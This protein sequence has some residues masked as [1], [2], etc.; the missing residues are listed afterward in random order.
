MAHIARYIVESSASAARPASVQTTASREQSCQHCNY[1]NNYYGDQ[2]C[3]PRT[4]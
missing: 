2:V 3:M 4:R 1:T